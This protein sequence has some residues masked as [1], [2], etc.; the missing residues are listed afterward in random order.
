[1]AY[2]K[3]NQTKINYNPS[4][5]ANLFLI[6]EVIDSKCSYNKPI[7]ITSVEDL[8]LYF[9]TS[10]EEFD[11]FNE[12]LNNKVSLYLYKPISNI[13]YTEIP[14]YSG[15]PEYKNLDMYGNDIGFYEI[16]ELPEET[17][18]KFYVISEE[19]YYVYDET[20]GFIN[21][22]N[23]STPEDYISLFNRDTLRLTSLDST[24]KYCHPKYTSRDY[25]PE[26]NITLSGDIS[27][28]IDKYQE[29][30]DKEEKSIAYRINF[31][32]VTDFSGYI[33]L[34]DDYS[35]LVQF[36]FDNTEDQSMIPP[37]G[38]D[39]IK[40][41]SYNVD[42]SGTKEETIQNFLDSIAAASYTYIKDGDDYII[43]NNNVTNNFQF[44]DLPGFTMTP[45]FKTNQEIIS[46]I[47]E[48]YKRAEFY[49]KTIGPGDEDI[50]ITIEKI[51]GVIEKYRVTVS[52]Y[53]YKEVHEGTLYITSDE[54]GYMLPLL[55]TEIN[56]NSK[57]IEAKFFRKHQDSINDLREGTYY[58]K[59]AVEENNT[60]I[61]FLNSLSIMSESNIQEDFLLIPDIY[62]YV[63]KGTKDNNYLEEYKYLLDYSKIKNC[64]VLITNITNT[65]GCY[66]EIRKPEKN[67]EKNVMYYNEEKAYYT[68]F[69]TKWNKVFSGDNRWKEIVDGYGKNNCIF[70]LSDE[71]NRLVYFYENMEFLGNDRPGYYLF[72][73]GILTGT[74]SETTD[75]LLY[76][77]PKPYEDNK[78]LEKYK[79]NYLC[80]NN[81]IF[82]Y[83][84]FFNHIGDW[85]YKTTIL[86]RFV[87][88]K[89]SNVVNKEFLGLLGDSWGNIIEKMRNI[90][91]ILR[92][93]YLLIK[94]IRITSIEEHQEKGI[95]NV[96]LDVYINE[97]TEKDIKI[98][99]TLNINN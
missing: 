61:G 40:D 13:T 52:R 90:L 39:V 89:I 76:N 92:N 42:S 36:Y 4:R 44:F 21:L 38:S 24:I 67:L 51:K 23:Y 64:Q 80:C 79:S 73:K 15:Y 25:T 17:G 19:S 45:D 97:L 57:L 26:Y 96:N 12:L 65:F 22:D 88:D 9:G 83:N 55:E 60:P 37:L 48:I 5:G 53:S 54:N 46:K 81:H 91:D 1:M 69:D 84:K 63:I 30:L 16:S 95:I 8:I 41:N 56:R 72:L 49:S 86:T 58:L 32:K 14:D 93:R 31:S 59:G 66:G 82:Y 29:E 99:L 11:Y 71:E 43:Y 3:L 2:L 27:E 33:V 98:N 70:N 34:E 94:S 6:S 74:Y 87:M 7:I 68:W 18:Y 20:F 77:S 50:K 28:K 85:N 78:E 47:T 75:L 10:F 35:E 62:K